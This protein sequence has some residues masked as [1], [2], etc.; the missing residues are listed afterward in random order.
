MPKKKK[1]YENYTGKTDFRVFARAVKLLNEDLSRDPDDV[2]YKNIE[3]VLGIC[4]RYL[5]NIAYDVEVNIQSNTATM[6]I[7]EVSTGRVLLQTTDTTVL[8]NGT[9]VVM[10]ISQG[11]GGPAFCS[12]Q[13]KARF[14]FAELIAD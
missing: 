12:D 7:T 14:D 9:Q 8:N 13:A 10:A 11:M 2:E 6:E 3:D 1:D 4:N 5:E